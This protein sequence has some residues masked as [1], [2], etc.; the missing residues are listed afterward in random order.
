MLS[1]SYL[2]R[3]DRNGIDRFSVTLLIP[4]VT[5]FCASYFLDGTLCDSCLLYTILIETIVDSYFSATTVTVD[6]SLHPFVTAD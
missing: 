4:K 1:V 2:L 5:L 3:Y 6:S